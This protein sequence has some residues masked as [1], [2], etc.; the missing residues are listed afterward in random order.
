[1]DE[2]MTLNM[3]QKQNEEI[4][5]AVKRE[6]K[7][8]LNFIR[9]RVRNNE[10]AEDVL[11]DVMVQFVQTYRMTQSIDRVTS[12]LFTV[13]RNRIIDLYRKKKPD[14]LEE[15]AS[16]RKDDEGLSL[17]ISDFLP[18]PNGDPGMQYARNLVWEE[19]YASLDELPNEQSA[20]F[21]M[22]ELE[23]KNFKEISSETGIGVATLISRK[24]YAVLFLRK[25]LQNLYD[26]IVNHNE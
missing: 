18:D 17:N 5:Q 13:A 22:H 3:T 15:Y 7:G 1:M 25:R 16:V 10:D 11:Q 20:V 9:K 24:R 8:L 19:L 26:E 4:Q 23:G 12:W 6:R 21:V 2:T 14:S